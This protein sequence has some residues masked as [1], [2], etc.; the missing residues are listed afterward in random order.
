MTIHNMA[1][2]ANPNTPQKVDALQLIF[3]LFGAPH[4]YGALRSGSTQRRNFG[5]P[6]YL[7]LLPLAAIVA[8]GIEFCIM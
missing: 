3:F 6:A 1:S 2:P 4:I 5:L 8:G 7:Y